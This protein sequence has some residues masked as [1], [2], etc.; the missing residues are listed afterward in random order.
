MTLTRQLILSGMFVLLC[1]FVGTNY[2]V[3]KNTQA[4]LD[5]QLASHSQD[6][7]TAMG[8]CLTLI[9][10]NNDTITAERIVDAIW[11]RGYYKLIE[12][13]GVDGSI[14]A[15]RSG[16]SKVYKVPN[17]FIEKFQIATEKKE[18]LV[19]DGWRKVGKVII[20][21]NP[22]FAYKQIWL[23]FI[24]SLEWL[25]L[26][27]VVAGL[28]GSILLYIILRP[29]RAVTLQAAAICNQQFSIQERLPWT[30]D[31]RQV[32]EAMNNMS[33]RLKA[34]FEN[35]A[36]VSE[37]LRE[38]AFKDPVTK[39]SNRRFFDLQFD[40]LLQDK[41]QGEGGALLLVELEAFKEYN[42]KFGYEGG[43]KLL[44]NTAGVLQS[45]CEKYDNAI[46]THAKGASFFI[47]LPSKTKTVGSTVAQNICDNFN[48]FKTK[49]LSN[50]EHVGNIGLAV[51]QPGDTKKEIMSQLDM[52][53]RAAQ[54][55]GHN[56]WHGLA[57]GMSQEIKSAGE[58]ASLFEQVIRENKIVLHFQE[59][60]L[61][62][63]EKVPHF[64]TLLRLVE[65][66]KIIT[67]GVF[68][69]MAEQ[70]NQMLALDKLVVEN[71]VQRI[72]V[73]RDAYQ[74]TVNLSPSSFDD[75]AFKKWL[76][77]KVSALGKQA[78]QLVI[79]L[80]EFG[81]VNRIEKMRDFFLKFAKAGGKTSIDHYGKNFSSFSYLYN[82]KLNYLKIDGGYIKEIHAN[83]ENKFFVRSL[84]DIAHSLDI[85]V[86]AESVETQEEYDTL[87]ALKVDGVQ[88]YF[89]GKPTP[90]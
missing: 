70:L 2:Y 27:S 82:L 60:K 61:W 16:Q 35:Q 24:D 71:V 67:A 25:L 42:D 32:V 20:E 11:D 89:I 12:I 23:T 80:P 33:R 19:M 28:L 65:G 34:L 15:K 31:L 30:I 22:G 62:G 45:C 68:M 1:L 72:L 36:K 18:A 21:S 8:L 48:E 73:A 41:E 38:Q 53:L 84:V 5:D 43:D 64:E 63:K 52:S 47:I 46:V 17:W 90:L 74:Y 29:L 49:N 13:Q 78:N 58:W 88:G 7:A 40:F 85:Y 14:I 10:Q 69:P 77:E 56:T 83:E 50:L 87:K 51:F 81:I 76:I 57:G 44:I 55:K 86:I 9:M 79:E 59:T 75:M 39:L 6:T 66:E 37:Q 26:T 4:F 3:V 54:A